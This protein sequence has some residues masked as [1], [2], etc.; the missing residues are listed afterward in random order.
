MK[1]I[2]NITIIGG[3]TSA[4]IFALIVKKTFPNLNIKI[5]ESDRLGIVGVGEGSTEHWQSFIRFCDISDETIIKECGATYKLGIRYNGWGKEDYMHSLTSEMNRSYGEYYPYYG[6]IISNKMPS[7]KFQKESIWNN[8]LYAEQNE[9]PSRQYHFHA[10]KLNEFLHKIC[11]ERNIEFYN[12]EIVDVELSES[13]HVLNV[14]SNERI[15]ES[16]FFV[17]STGFF[18]FL[19][20]KKLEVPWISYKKHLPVDSAIAFPTDEMEEYNLWTNVT[21]HS[22]GWSWSAPVQGRTGNGYVYCGDFISK[23]E[24]HIEME[25]F[26]GKDLQIFKEFKFDPGR[27]E[28]FWYKNCLAI[29]IS[30]SFVEPLEATSIGSTILQSF[31]FVNCLPSHDEKTYNESMLGLFQNVLDYVVCHYITVKEDTAF[32]RF[33][34]NELV[35][36]DSLQNLLEKWKNRLPQFTDIHYPWSMFGAPNYIPMLYANNLFDH[37]KIKKE[38]DYFS[39][40]KNV[41]NDLARF[42]SFDSMVPKIGHKEA[43]FNIINK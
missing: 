29:G 24:A 23:D 30:G 25:Q 2:N 39:F 8:Q 21:A 22:S 1:K 7:R 13:G 17:D 19:L 31:C 41:E 32:W 20:H 18:R 26:F 4:C 33:V 35:I 37:D 34:K 15:Y 9:S 42:E 12:D 40:L 38:F 5:I 6:Y 3:G 43:I 16:D 27:L 10:Y 28:K 36:P 14:K 11:I